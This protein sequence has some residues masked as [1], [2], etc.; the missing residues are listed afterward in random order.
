VAFA[1]Q[2]PDCE[3]LLVAVNYA[4]NQSQ[5][6][7]PLPFPNLAGRT[8]RFQDLMSAACY[9]YPGDGLQSQGL[10]LDMPAWGYH[11]FDVT[12]AA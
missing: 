7:L 10:Y 3:R 9:V 5:C 1:W 12:M 2:G 6:Y 4:S 8:I 11:V